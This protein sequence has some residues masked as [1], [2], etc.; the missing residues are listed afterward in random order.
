[1]NSI[2]TKEVDHE[3]SEEES[4][5]IIPLYIISLYYKTVSERQKSHSKDHIGS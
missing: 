5:S 2:H 4:L 3:V 1:M